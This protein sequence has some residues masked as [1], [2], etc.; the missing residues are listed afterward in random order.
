MAS[1]YSEDIIKQARNLYILDGMSA[2]EV[3]DKL[4]VSVNTV[5]N[6]ASKR[7]WTFVRG[8]VKDI[9]YGSEMLDIS[10]QVRLVY[11]KA[12]ERLGLMLEVTKT[13]KQMSDLMNAMR[14]IDERLS[15]H[16]AIVELIESKHR[17]EKLGFKA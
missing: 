6:W 7:K 1:K 14:V 9:E 16:Y 8:S 10:E 4:N 5:G 2:Q 13:P 17:R 15:W 11:E 3:A 12:L